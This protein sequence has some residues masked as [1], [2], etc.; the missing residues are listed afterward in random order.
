MYV[1]Q[2][3]WMNDVVFIKWTVYPY[4]RQTT[5]GRLIQGLAIDYRLSLTSVMLKQ[6]NFHKFQKKIS[7]VFTRG[8][9]DA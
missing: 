8:H 5:T 4:R 1:I 7:N 2:V 9:N 3:L 6:I